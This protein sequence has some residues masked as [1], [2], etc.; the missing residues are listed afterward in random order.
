M[1]NRTELEN[2]IR[3]EYIAT[4]T[5]ALAADNDIYRVASNKI[6]L[7]AVDA[8]GNDKWMTITVSI[9][10]DS[11]DM[12]G[13]YGATEQAAYLAKIAEKEAKAEKAAAEKAKKI[14]ADQ[15]RRAEKAA[16]KAVKAAG[17]EA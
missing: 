17:S 7:A 3:N 16:A 9:L 11:E 15:K 2:A 6:M 13:D 12:D 5:E 8:E 10:K 1:A 4:L 14:A